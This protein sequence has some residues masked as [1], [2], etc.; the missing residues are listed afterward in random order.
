LD[1]TPLTLNKLLAV[2]KKKT[3]YKKTQ[4]IL[5]EVLDSDIYISVAVPGFYRAMHHSA[6][7]GI[8]IKCHQCVTLVN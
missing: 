7:C 1:E 5:V 4:Y 8:A 3:Q 2:F 6:K